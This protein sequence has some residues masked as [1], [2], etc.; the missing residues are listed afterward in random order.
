MTQ[1]ERAL[2]WPTSCGPYEIAHHARLTQR[3][4]QMIDYELTY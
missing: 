1:V 4:M 3:A 2:Q